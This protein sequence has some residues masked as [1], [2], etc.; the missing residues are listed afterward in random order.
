MAI[1]TINNTNFIENMPAVTRA[2][3]SQP[4]T[5]GLQFDYHVK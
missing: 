5:V 1:L 4:R 2:T 3:V